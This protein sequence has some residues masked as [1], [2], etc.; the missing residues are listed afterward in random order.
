MKIK[1]IPWVDTMPTIVEIKQELKALGVRGYS[2]KN[3]AE[4]LEM[5]E[6]AKAPK[7]EQKKERKV[8]PVLYVQEEKKEAP[9]RMVVLP[10]QVVEEEDD[11]SIPIIPEVIRE[12]MIDKLRQ[13]YDTHEYKRGLAHPIDDILNWIGKL[14]DRRPFG[15]YWLIA[16]DFL[17]KLVKWIKA[18]S[19][20]AT[21][22]PFIDKEMKEKILLLSDWEAFFKANI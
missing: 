12:I 8:K 16:N 19:H 4:L 22:F 3:K 10:K 5:L 14:K 20:E 18:N 11:R 6:K 7:P 21:A 13:D 17:T 9:K 1:Y 15:K 2:C